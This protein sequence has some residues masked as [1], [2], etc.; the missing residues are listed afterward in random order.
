MVFS[1]LDRVPI[2]VFAPLRPGSR[3]RRREHGGAAFRVFVGRVKLCEAPPDPRSI[4][5]TVGD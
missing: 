4:R 2:A 5:R 3:T 1:F